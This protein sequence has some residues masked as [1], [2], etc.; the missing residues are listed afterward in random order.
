MRR[1]GCVPFGT[2]CW[3]DLWDDLWQRPMPSPDAAARHT[4]AG[5]A[6]RQAHHERMRDER[7]REAAAG[8]AELPPE[9]D[10]VEMAS[11]AQLLDSVAEVGPNYTLLRSKETKAKRRK[12]QR[13][14][15][16]AALDGHTVL[17]TGSRLEIFC[18]SERWYPATVMAREEDGDGRIAHQVEYDGYPDRR[19]WHMLDDERLDA[20]L[21][22]WGCHKL[23]AERATDGVPAEVMECET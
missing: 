10:A 8:D 15:A 20:A 12:R 3:Y 11:A 1:F 5:V 16:R 9:D 4:G 14:D 6:R 7:A 13:E 17:S 18:D 2:T 22:L 21:A 19:W 23:A